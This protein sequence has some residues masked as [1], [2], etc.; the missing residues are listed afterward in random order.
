[1]ALDS[2]WRVA[3]F[4]TV[5]LAQLGCRV[6]EPSSRPLDGCRS[7]CETTAKD[8][9][10]RAGCERGC[11]MI[12][13]RVL[14]GEADRVLACVAERAR[15]CADEVWA[16]CAAHVGAHADGGP[17]GPPPPDDDD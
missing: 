3:V 10:S 13:D 4:C 1:M 2:S 15:G 9:C 7:A 16:D 11:E 14:E 17:P 5:A 6:L 12:L 8:P